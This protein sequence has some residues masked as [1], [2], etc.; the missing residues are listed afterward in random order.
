[1]SGVRPNVLLLTG[2]GNVELLKRANPFGTSNFE[3]T[4]RSDKA[5]Y[6]RTKEDAW[7]ELILKSFLL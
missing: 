4:D 3:I 7:E 1:M 5:S 6:R 2:N